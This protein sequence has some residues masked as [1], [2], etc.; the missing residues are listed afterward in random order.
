MQIRAAHAR[1]KDL[2]EDLLGPRFGLRDVHGIDFACTCEADGAHRPREARRRDKPFHLTDI[3]RVARQADECDSAWTGDWMLARSA[4]A[5]AGPTP[6]CARRW[7]S[8]AEIQAHARG[9]RA[10]RTARIRVGR[11]DFAETHQTQRR[12]LL[13][14]TATFSETESAVQNVLVAQRLAPI[15]GGSLEESRGMW[16]RL[17]QKPLSLWVI[18]AGVLYLRLVFFAVCF[19]PVV[20]VS[21]QRRWVYVTAAVVRLVFFSLTITEISSTTANPADA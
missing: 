21:R 8:E 17:K 20:F 2:H 11:R 18:A 15:R 4:S 13:R 5:L 7:S 12:R 10:L 3:G 6:R 1:G 14:G 9:G 19:I 16:A